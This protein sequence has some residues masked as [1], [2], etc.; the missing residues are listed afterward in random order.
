[1]AGEETVGSSVGM[2]LRLALFQCHYLIY[3]IHGSLIKRNLSVVFLFTV[4]VWI[5][6][7]PQK[8]SQKIVKK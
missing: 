1:M 8:I 2:L 7:F 4:I 6:I 5:K 3:Y